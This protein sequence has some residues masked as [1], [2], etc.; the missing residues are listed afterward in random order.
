[1]GNKRGRPKSSAVEA[2]SKR[3]VAG[4]PSVP[5]LLDPDRFR[6]MLILAMARKRAPFKRL[7][8]LSRRL[9]AAKRSMSRRW[10]KGILKS[11]Q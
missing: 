6:L 3:A 1:M 4:R 11:P 5:V 2:V 8:K 10:R 7:A 9:S